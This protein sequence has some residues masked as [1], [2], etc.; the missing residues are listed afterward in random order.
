MLLPEHQKKGLMQEA[1]AAVLN[2]GFNVI[3]LHSVEANVNPAN[4]NSKK[5]LEKNKF[6]RGAYFRENYYYN[7]QFMDSAI[8]SL[9]TPI[10]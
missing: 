1:A 3:Q 2:Y 4:E 6:V 7:G 8:F 5:F 9:L 10:K